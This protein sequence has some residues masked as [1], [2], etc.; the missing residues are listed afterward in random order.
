MRTL[1]H[2]AHWN[3][4]KHIASGVKGAKAMVRHRFHGLLGVVVLSLAGCNSSGS[5]FANPF[6]SSQP[7]QQIAAVQPAAPSVP[8]PAGTR[9]TMQINATPKR[10]QD[11]IVAR[12]QR[13]GT[14]VLGAN[15]TGVTLEVPLRQSSP[16]VIQQCGEH[17][18]GRTLRVYLETQ[19]NGAGTTV[20]EQR[21]VID[22]GAT[23]CE[24]QLT[25]SDIDEANKSLA[26][27]K[28]QS[29]APRTAANRPADPA[30]GL[31]P[32]NPTRPVQPLR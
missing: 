10:V 7:R 23:S 30:G 5:P 14:M 16:V 3:D 15:S 18:E 8:S 26:D 17:K 20:T 22:G 9:P 29:E 28:Q 4:R 2:R 1:I 21:F 24:V 12:A 6:G 13:R 19:P 11:M 32:L 27:L 25:Q 31:E